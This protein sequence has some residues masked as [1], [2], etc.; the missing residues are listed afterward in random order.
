MNFVQLVLEEHMF[1]I[2]HKETP[3]TLSA[4][5]KSLRIGI[6]RGRCYGTDVIYGR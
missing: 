2:N 3:M 1:H 4:I 5:S 6:L